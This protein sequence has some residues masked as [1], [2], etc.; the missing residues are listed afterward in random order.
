MRVLTIL[1]GLVLLLPGL[2]GIGGGVVTLMTIYEALTRGNVQADLVWLF[3]LPSAAGLG[4]G[5][6]GI[7]LLRSAARKPG[8]PPEASP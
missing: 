1:F 3:A 6:F 5:W 8:R 7:W 2:C 4:L